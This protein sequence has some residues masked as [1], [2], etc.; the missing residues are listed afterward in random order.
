M[1][2]LTLFRKAF[3]TFTSIAILFAKTSL[4]MSS[5]GVIVIGIL[6]QATA[7]VSAFST[8]AFQKR[9]NLSS[10]TLMVYSVAGVIVMCA[11]VL[12]GL[13]GDLRYGG[14]KTSGEMYA[15]AIWFGIV[16]SLD[17]C[18]SQSGGTFVLNNDYFHSLPLSADV[19][20]I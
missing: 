18:S 1:C 6:T 12:V 7:I 5:S 10:M 17:R 8:P 4:G 2:H 15:C 9:F 16:S 11:Y 19:R 13:I 14:L 3:N 20:S